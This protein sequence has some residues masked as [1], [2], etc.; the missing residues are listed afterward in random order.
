MKK[1]KLLNENEL[2][3]LDKEVENKVYNLARL[4]ASDREICSTLDYSIKVFWQ[5][6]KKKAGR[7]E[8]LEMLRERPVLRARMSLLKGID[9]DPHL[10]LKY[11]ERVRKDEF[12]LSNAQNGSSGPITVNVVA[13]MPRPYEQQQIQSGNEIEVESEEV[14]GDGTDLLTDREGVLAR[15]FY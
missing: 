9:S 11:L 6:K 10:A 4:G 15:R 7:A 8:Y 13:N 2:L 1:K 14:D 12:S 3:E 5:W